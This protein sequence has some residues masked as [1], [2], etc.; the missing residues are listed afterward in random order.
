[1]RSR[2]ELAPHAQWE[3]PT[4]RR[5]ALNQE[6]GYSGHSQMPPPL[7]PYS[8]ASQPAPPGRLRQLWNAFWA[9]FFFSVICG[10]LGVTVNSNLRIRDLPALIST[11]GVAASQ[12]TVLGLPP[13]LAGASWNDV[14][15]LARV[16]PRCP[17]VAC[18]GRCGAGADAQLPGCRP[19]PGAQG[20]T[21]RFASW[22]DA[23]AATPL[24]DPY[25]V[26]TLGS[27]V[28]ADYGVIV[29]Q[30]PLASTSDAVANVTAAARA[31]A[32]SNIDLIWINGK[33]FKA[34]ATR[35][36]QRRVRRLATC[37]WR[38]RALRAADSRFP[39]ARVHVGFA[40]L[41]PPRR[42]SSR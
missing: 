34:R 22:S 10:I 19:S 11:A 33:N 12:S 28:L 17:A 2:D 35:T 37:Q 23:T 13:P 14:L 40:P 30:I 21:V 29:R 9:L 1:M 24:V 27:A 38:G 36:A 15:A 6:S 42:G 4:T 18:A 20:T 31:G 25:I 8:S 16:R 39:R 5:A 7:A 32:A 41:G 26:N 3:L